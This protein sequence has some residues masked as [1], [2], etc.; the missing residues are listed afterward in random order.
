[1]SQSKT[2]TCMEKRGRELTTQVKIQTKTGT[3]CGEKREGKTGT[4]P[5]QRPN[6]KPR[7]GLCVEGNMPLVGILDW[8]KLACDFVT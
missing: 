4:H 8:Q 5:S 1:M 7:R 6:P 2:E 3:L